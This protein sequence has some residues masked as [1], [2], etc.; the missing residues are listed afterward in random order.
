MHQRAGRAALWPAQRIQRKHSCELIVEWRSRS[1]SWR[2]RAEGLFDQRD[3]SNPKYRVAFL[4]RLMRVIF[5]SKVS[6]E[7]IVVSRARISTIPNAE[8]RSHRRHFISA[9]NVIP[10]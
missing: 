9:R 1:V 10:P 4:G 2:M 5:V 6:V 3:T 8:E 7:T